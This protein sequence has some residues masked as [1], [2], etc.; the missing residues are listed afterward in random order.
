MLDIALKEWAVVCDLLAEGKLAM[1]LRKGGIHERHGQFGIDHDRFTLFPAWM[2]QRPELLKPA[3]RGRVETFG[4][5]PDTITFGAMAEVSRIWQV[6]SRVAFDQLDQLHPWS[7]EQIDIRFNYKPEKPLYL[8]SLRVYRLAE[9]QTIENRKRYA[10]C[11][12]WV[13]LVEEDHVDETG[14]TP[15]LSDEAFTLIEREIDRA[16]AG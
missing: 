7:P 3:Y 11:R 10:G 14:R 6:T 12:S 8:V 4:V 9:T 16:M 13:P 15:A 5:E 2:H 1:L